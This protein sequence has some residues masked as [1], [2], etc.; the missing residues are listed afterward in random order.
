MGIEEVKE[1]NEQQLMSI[2]GV[3]GVAIGDSNGQ[4]TIIVMVK[5]E[6]SELKQHVPH[7][8]EGYPVTIDFTGEIRA[9]AF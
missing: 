2:P 8:L 5:N 9:D 1:R 6:S 4:P 7:R 3:V